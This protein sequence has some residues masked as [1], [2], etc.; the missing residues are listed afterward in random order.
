MTPI[1]RFNFVMWAVQ[2][3]PAFTT[4]PAAY[5]QAVRAWQTRRELQQLTEAVTMSKSATNNQ[6]ETA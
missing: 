5:E 3:F 1:E 2:E 4:N 6:G